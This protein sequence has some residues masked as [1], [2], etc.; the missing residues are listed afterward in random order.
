MGPAEGERVEALELKNR[1]K[2][3]EAR[4]LKRED[5]DPLPPARGSREHSK[6]EPL[7]PDVFALC[8][9]T[10]TSPEQKTKCSTRQSD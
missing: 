2:A 5:S 9:V 7:S 4:V 6:T 3:E 1:A 10:G 8:I